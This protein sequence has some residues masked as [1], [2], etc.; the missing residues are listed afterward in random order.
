[1]YELNLNEKVKNKKLHKKTQV[2]E[3]ENLFNEN[4]FSIFY[5]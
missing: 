3:I 4:D 5:I 2:L 1:L